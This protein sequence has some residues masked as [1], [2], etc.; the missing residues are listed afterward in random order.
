M[1]DNSWD[2]KK[3][4]TPLLSED[5]R[6]QYIIPIKGKEAIL[7]DGLKKLGH[8]KGIKSLKTDILQFPNVD[9]NNLCIVK[10]ELIGYDYDPV[11]EKIA[12]VSYSAIGDASPANCNRLVATAF[13]RMAETR[14]IARVLKNYT[15]VGIVGVDEIFD[16]GNNNNSN[17]NSNNNFNNNSNNN[18]NNNSNNTQIP[19]ISKQQADSFVAVIKQKNIPKILSSYLLKHITKKNKFSDLNSQEANKLLQTF[20]SLTPENIK[21]ITDKLEAMKAQKQNVN[22]GQ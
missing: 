19:P 15:D 2:Y 9:N 6:K 20:N 16:D 18:F 14:A 17:N 12:E 8:L 13:V 21:E 5:F 4:V 3:G 10:A 7:S 22:N 11:Q 1:T